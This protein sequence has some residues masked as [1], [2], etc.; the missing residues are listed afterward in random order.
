[1]SH[2]VLVK[3]S[4]RARRLWKS[5]D[6]VRGRRSSTSCPSRYPSFTRRRLVNVDT[7]ER[8][9]PSSNAMDLSEAPFVSK[10]ATRFSEALRSPNCT[11]R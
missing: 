10:R 1:M 11:R 6:R 8:V 4:I 2:S 3:R 5:V 7:V 9:T